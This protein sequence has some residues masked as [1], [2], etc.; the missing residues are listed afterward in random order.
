MTKEFPNNVVERC[1]QG[2]GRSFAEG[3]AEI[4]AN[5]AIDGTQPKETNNLNRTEGDDI[6][7]ANGEDEEKIK[8]SSSRKAKEHQSWT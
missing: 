5:V 4:A 7:N 1:V 6:E 3:R 8:L 2:M